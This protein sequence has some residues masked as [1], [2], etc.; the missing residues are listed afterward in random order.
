MRKLFIAAFAVL[1]F[2][3]ANAQESGFKAGA[4]VG[5][6]IGTAGDAYSLNFG[7][8]FAYMYSVS[9]DFKVGGTA[10]YTM[11]T[12]KDVNGFKFPSAGLALVGAAAT[13]NVAD[14][15]FVGADLG[16]GI[17]VSNVTGGDIFYHPKV[18]YSAETFEATLGYRGIGSGFTAVV[19]GFAYKF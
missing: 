6:P 5:L 15:F 3:L 18:G 13:Y 17:G 16:Y 7:V 12:G 9:D 8:D 1:S 2:G 14:S 10:G 11:F 4:H 19:A